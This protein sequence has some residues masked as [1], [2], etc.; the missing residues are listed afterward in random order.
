MEESLLRSFA[1]LVGEWSDI[2]CR[3]HNLAPL[4]MKF[5]IE[6]RTML[7]K[8]SILDWPTLGSALTSVHKCLHNCEL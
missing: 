1:C 6:V 2:S 8:L 7:R 3:F 4:R 5:T